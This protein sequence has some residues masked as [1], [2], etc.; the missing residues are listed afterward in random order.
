MKKEKKINELEY[1]I[2]SD[3]VFADLNL[4]N[5]EELL[6]KSELVF[7]INNLIKEKK[8]NQIE[9]ANLLD[10]D[11]PKISDLKRGKLSRFSL[12]RLIRFLD[13]L[14]HDVY[15]DVKPRIQSKKNLLKLP[16]LKNEIKNENRIYA[17][18]NN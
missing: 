11:Q 8:L 3:N 2:G 15:L 14:D 16:I 4:P 13:K 10:V 18:K 12:E 6:K 17:K 7:K 9:A 1:E 5:P